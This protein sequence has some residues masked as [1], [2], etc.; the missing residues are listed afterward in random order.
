MNFCRK[1]CSWGLSANMTHVEWRFARADWK[2]GLLRGIGLRGPRSTVS[3]GLLRIS[4][5]EGRSTGASMGENQ[6]SYPPG[7]RPNPADRQV[8]VNAA[9][10]DEIRRPALAES[11]RKASIEGNPGYEPTTDRRSWV[12]LHA[13]SPQSMCSKRGWKVYKGH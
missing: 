4:S 13:D 7:P 9:A 8:I 5:H 10:E 1:H 3:S 11:F 2:F 6:G 12:I